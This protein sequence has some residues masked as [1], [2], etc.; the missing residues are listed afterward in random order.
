[1]KSLI[2]AVHC[3]ESPIQRETLQ[4]EI[5]ALEADI[6]YVRKQCHLREPNELKQELRKDMFEKD[7]Q[8]RLGNHYHY[9][10]THMILLDMH[11]VQLAKLCRIRKTLYKAVAT[12][13][14]ME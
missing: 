7:I 3:G 8:H 14:L 6:D 4:E 12:E 10:G 1:M 9:T 5:V 11:T 2:A 13:T